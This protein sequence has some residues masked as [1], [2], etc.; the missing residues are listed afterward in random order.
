ME[1]R[2][3]SKIAK[4][5]A[6]SLCYCKENKWSHLNWDPDPDQEFCT[7]TDC[8]NTTERILLAGWSP[9]GLTLLRL[10]S[11]LRP[12]LIKCNLMWERWTLPARRTKPLA[13]PLLLGSLLQFLLLVNQH[14]GE[15]LVYAR[16]LN[17]ME[18]A[19]WDRRPWRRGQCD[20]TSLVRLVL[21]TLWTKDGSRPF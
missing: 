15:V 3:F 9:L 18:M 19:T 13:T 10:W 17:D 7:S 14:P 12:Q 4:V 11:L 5:M 1:E 21:S 6:R 20:N 8:G 16:D 2:P